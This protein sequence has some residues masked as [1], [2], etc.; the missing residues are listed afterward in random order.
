MLSCRRT[1]EPVG[2]RDSTA[3]VVSIETHPLPYF[4]LSLQAPSHMSRTAAG[5]FVMVQ[6]QDRLEP[7][8]RRPFSVFDVRPT[9]EGDAEVR[10]LG[11]VVGRGTRLLANVREGDC[12]PLLG[13]LGRPFSIVGDGP[14]ALVAGGVGSAA[15]LLLARE[16]VRRRLRFDFYYGGRSADDLAHRELFERLA[17]EVGGRFVA[18]TEDGSLGHAGLV[19]EPLMQAL[20][21]RDLRFVYACGPMPL[22]ARVAELCTES[23]VAGQAALETPMGCGYGA[24]LGCAVPHAS[25]RWAL[26]CQDGPVFGFDEVCW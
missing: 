15:L 13:P 17:Y 2:P 18:T 20:E 24:C 7:Y 6:V 5:Q 4:T 11:K 22:L 9:D 3:R 14:V 26:C 25:G 10:L 1:M 8:L 12:L 21:R 23:G 16:L 19:T